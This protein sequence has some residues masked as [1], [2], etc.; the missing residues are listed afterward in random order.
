MNVTCP[1]CFHAFDSDEVLFR[2]G[3]PGCRKEEDTVFAEHWKS[4]TSTGEF[5]ISPEQRHLYAA[6]KKW[7]GSRDT[8]CDLCGSKKGYTYACPNCHNELPIPMVEKGA[9]IISVV[10]G[11]YSGKSHYIIALLHELKENGYKIGLRAT[12][13][14]IGQVDLRCDRMFNERLD[15]LNSRHEVLEKTQEKSVPIP[16]VIRIDSTDP[17]VR[18]LQEPKKTIYLVF[19]DTAG[20]SFADKDKVNDFAPYF[21]HSVGAIVFFDTL[22]IPAIQKIMKANQEDTSA[23]EGVTNFGKTWEAL[24]NIRTNSSEDSL[25]GK[26]F[27]FVLSKFDFVLNHSADLSFDISDFRDGNGNPKDKSFKNGMKKYDASVVKLSNDAIEGALEEWGCGNYVS[28]ANTY[29][30]PCCFFGISAIGDMPKDG[31]IPED[32]IKPYRVMD[33]LLWIMSKIGG[34]AFETINE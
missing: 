26:P 20:E 25:K 3:N 18:G 9:S 17:S 12:L 4:Y 27:A 33:P 6:R 1:Y 31:K 30:Q 11:P 16:W 24:N 19:Y 5:Q 8:S 32:G 15:T 29:Y 7:W 13:Q 22:S 23:L 14:Q 2:C 10:G 21:Q 34:F 28:E